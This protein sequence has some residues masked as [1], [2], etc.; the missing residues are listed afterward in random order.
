MELTCKEIEKETA[1]YQKPMGEGAVIKITKVNKKR[2]T[3]AQGKMN[4]M[5]QLSNS[6]GAV[7]T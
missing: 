7:Q 6:V 4:E 1:Y 5:T 3:T 2:K